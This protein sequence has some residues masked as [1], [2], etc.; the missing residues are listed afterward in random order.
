MWLQAAMNPGGAA[1]PFCGFSHSL[2]KSVERLLAAFLE[3]LR[4]G[5]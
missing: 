4:D 2:H 1:L 3:R 5:L